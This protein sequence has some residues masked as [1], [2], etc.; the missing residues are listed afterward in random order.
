M[1]N[2]AMTIELEKTHFSY[3]NAQEMGAAI[4]ASSGHG[5]THINVKSTTFSENSASLSLIKLENVDM[6]IDNCVMLN[7]TAKSVTHGF[8]MSNSKLKFINTIVR[9]EKI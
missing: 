9:N 4:M 8:S 7:N 5:K 2:E 1:L 3:N 6:T